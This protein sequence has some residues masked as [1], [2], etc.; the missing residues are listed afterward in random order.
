MV[1]EIGQVVPNLAL[2]KPELFNTIAQTWFKTSW[3]IVLS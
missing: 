1:T 3:D 2:T